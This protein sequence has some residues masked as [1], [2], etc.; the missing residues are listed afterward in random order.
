MNRFLLF[1]SK[2]M[3][4][5]GALVRDFVASFP[6]LEEAKAGIGEN[7][8]EGHDVPVIVEYDGTSL[9]VVLVWS[10]TFSNATD[11]IIWRWAEPYQ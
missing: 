5:R 8:E 3:W 1:I 9:A 2:D 6:T 7:F 11:P 10:G 4:D